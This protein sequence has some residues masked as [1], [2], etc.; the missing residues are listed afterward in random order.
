MR[1]E[2]KK[3]NEIAL[4]SANEAQYWLSLLRDAGLAKADDIDPLL[5]EVVEFSNLL[6]AGVKKLKAR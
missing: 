5:A 3:F 4:K 1:L 6:A 2:F